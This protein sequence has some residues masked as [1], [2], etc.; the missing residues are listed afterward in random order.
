[1]RLLTTSIVGQICIVLYDAMALCSGFGAEQ[2][3][4]VGRNG[5]LALA[6]KSEFVR[7]FVR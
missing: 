6:I 4:V 3:V 7:S 1:M 2:I 5:Q